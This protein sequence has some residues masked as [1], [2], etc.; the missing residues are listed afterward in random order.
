MTSHMSLQPPQ[1]DPGQAETDALARSWRNTLLEMITLSI[2]NQPRSQQKTIGPSE[3]GDP[4]DHCLAA[5]LAGWTRN[6]PSVAWLPFI[7]TAVHALLEDM[8]NSPADGFLTERRVTVGTILGQPISGSTDLWIEHVGG[9]D[10]A[11]MTVDW[12]IVG[13]STL[14]KIKRTGE[15]TGTYRAQAHLYARGWNH[16]GKPTSHVAIFY[17]PRNAMSLADAVFWSEPY[18]EQ[19]AIDAL[20]RAE[21]IARSLQ[22]L[23]EALGTAG[24]DQHISSLPREPGC[25][26]CKKY[27]DWQTTTSGETSLNNVLNIF[28]G[29]QQ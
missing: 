19:I 18:D 17:L 9:T 6:E 10:T 24:R 25:W 3:I 23:E 1:H 26:N 22:A 11:G 15:P 27:D 14:D 12:K 2:R 5:R 16:A 13:K 21:R 20:A 7:G 4:C 8:F 28:G 29:T